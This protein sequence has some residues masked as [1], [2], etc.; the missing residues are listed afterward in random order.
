M[1]RRQDTNCEEILYSGSVTGGDVLGALKTSRLP[2]LFGGIE[3]KPQHSA[4]RRRYL[5][6][7]VL[8]TR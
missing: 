3:T 2:F 4:A 5:R 6:F 8:R 7:V 1:L